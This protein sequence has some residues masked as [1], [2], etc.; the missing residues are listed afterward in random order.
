MANLPPRPERP[1]T[2]GRGEK[3]RGNNWLVI[4]VALAMAVGGLVSMMLLPLLNFFPVIVIAVFG[5]IAFHHFVWGRWLT[6]VI[7]QEEEEEAND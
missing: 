5:F 1:A 3:P 4:I 6:K 2:P 7:R